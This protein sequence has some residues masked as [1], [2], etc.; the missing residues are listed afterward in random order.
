MNSR[1]LPEDRLATSD[2]KGN[3]IYLYPAEVRG[4]FRN[5]RSK[6]N[7]GL[8]LLFLGL[9]W[10]RMGG[11]QAVLLDIPNRRF[12]I[13]GLTFWA[14]DAPL[15]LFIFGGAAIGLAFVTAIWGRVWC[16]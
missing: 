2:Q 14:H 12:A 7:V 10:I 5:L 9:P 15:L 3:R 6:L 8:I 1:E 13:L 4:H 11:H 16:G